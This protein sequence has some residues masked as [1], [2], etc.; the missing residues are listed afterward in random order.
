MNYDDMSFV[1][2]KEEETKLR[3]IICKRI[4]EDRKAV[5]RELH[6]KF[7]KSV[8]HGDIKLIRTYANFIGDLIADQIIFNTEPFAG[9]YFQ[10]S[11]KFGY[12]CDAS[13]AEMTETSEEEWNKAY[14]YLIE[15]IKENTKRI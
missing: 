9:P 1:E 8:G 14:S 6:G 12:I 5:N 7:Y 4:D 3:K 2:L 13:V 10:A 11:I 15:T